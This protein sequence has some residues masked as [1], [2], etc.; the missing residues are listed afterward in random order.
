[1]LAAGVDDSELE[2]ERAR[3]L[4]HLVCLGRCSGLARIDQHGDHGS[5]WNQLMQQVQS[6]RF[7]LGGEE[8]NPG[9]VAAG[10]VETGD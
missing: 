1:M 7:H 6:L 9:A 4:G 8:G 10:P 2:P 5:A 3:S